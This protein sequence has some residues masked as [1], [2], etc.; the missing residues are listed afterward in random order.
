MLAGRL[1]EALGMRPY[2]VP[3]LVERGL[4]EAYQTQRFWVFWRTRYQCTPVGEAAQR[5]L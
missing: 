4:L 3:E 1:D 5:Q 2:R